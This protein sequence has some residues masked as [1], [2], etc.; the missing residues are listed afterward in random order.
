MAESGLKSTSRR[1]ALRVYDLYAGAGFRRRRSSTQTGLCSTWN[2]LCPCFGAPPISSIGSM[3]VPKNDMLNCSITL[4]YS[5]GM[6]MI[7]ATNIGKK[8]TKVFASS[9]AYDANGASQMAGA[10]AI[11]HTTKTQYLF[12]NNKGS[13]SVHDHGLINDFVPHEDPPV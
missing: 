9:F 7:K 3:H 4:S 8:F 10:P 12:R 2:R 6:E 13:L 11:H 1:G 5:S